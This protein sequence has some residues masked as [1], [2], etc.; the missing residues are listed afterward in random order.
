MP[1]A[2]RNGIAVTDSEIVGFAIEHPLERIV[3]GIV[4]APIEGIGFT[5]EATDDRI[6]VLIAAGEV[7]RIASRLG[8][9]WITKEKG[10]DRRPSLRPP[11]CAVSPLGR[12]CSKQSRWSPCFNN[13]ELGGAH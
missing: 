10:E 6:A 9:E 4:S 3:A 12:C 2:H 11:R 1:E 7:M 13:R 8:A 5:L